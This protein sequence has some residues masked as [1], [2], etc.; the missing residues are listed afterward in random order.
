MVSIH[1]MYRIRTYCCRRIC[2]IFFKTFELRN[3][4]LNAVQGCVIS[5]AYPQFIN[6][7]GERL[8]H[9]KL[10]LLDIRRHLN[11][12]EN[13]INFFEVD[14]LRV[15]V[16]HEATSCWITPIHSS[17][18]HEVIVGTYLLVGLLRLAQQNQRRNGDGM[19]KKCSKLLNILDY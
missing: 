9:L 3:V 6:M 18:F 14:H 2:C 15:E 7:S 16:E 5:L 17:V 12:V 19:L 13:I 1:R 8:N 4:I 11:F 10:L